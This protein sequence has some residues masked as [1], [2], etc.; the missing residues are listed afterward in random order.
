MDTKHP[1]PPPIGSRIPPPLNG[2]DL[3]GGAWVLGTPL[4]PQPHPVS[5]SAAAWIPVDYNP[6]SSSAADH[7]SYGIYSAASHA[8]PDNPYVHVYPVLGSSDKR[9]TDTIFKVLDR[10]GKKLEEKTRKTV[11]LACNV[12]QHLKIGPSMTDA[13]MAGLA[14]GTKVFAEGGNEKIFQQTF[15]VYAGEQLRKAFA[16]YLSTSTGPVIGTLYLSS[17]RLAFCS[18]NPLCNYTPSGQQQWIYY[19]VVVQLDQLNGVNPSFNTKNPTEKYIQ[20][21]TSDNHEFW[22][23]GFVSYDKALQHLRD[24]SQLA[25]KKYNN[26]I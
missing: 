4:I 11:N 19:K 25:H 10:C 5:R 8:V 9:P 15:G 2:S 3:Q 16:C 17:L 6:I 22:F 18:D 21:V 24:A 1:T 20:I 26:Q 14:H 7:P 12:W 23:M 13:A